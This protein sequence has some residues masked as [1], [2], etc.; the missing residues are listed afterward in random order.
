M[1]TKIADLMARRVIVAE[2]HHTVAH[3]RG[4]FERSRISAVPVVGPEGE[5]LGIVSKTDLARPLKDGTPIGRIMTK[6]VRRIPQYDDVASA[7]RAMRRHKVHHLIVTHEKKVVGVIGA[8]D[9]LKLVENHRFV[10]KPAT[11]KKKNGR[12]GRSASA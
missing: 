2:P 4:L 12:A 9:L 10:A 11:T 1:T 3:V 5:A 8:F 6:E 7:A